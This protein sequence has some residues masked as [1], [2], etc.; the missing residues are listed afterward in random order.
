MCDPKKSA[1]ENDSRK[2]FFTKIN[3]YSNLYAVEIGMGDAYSHKFDLVSP[4]I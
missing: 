2:E 4:R 1:T 3:K